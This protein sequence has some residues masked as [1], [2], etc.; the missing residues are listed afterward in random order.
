N[1]VNQYSEP[2]KM[3]TLLTAVVTADVLKKVK[4]D[5]FGD[6]MEVL[7]QPLKQYC[8]MKL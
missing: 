7:R 4:I 5:Q 8:C 1:D 3:V 2:L 6:F